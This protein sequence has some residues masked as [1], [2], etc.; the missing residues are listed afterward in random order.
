MLERGEKNQQKYL[1]IC[2][3]Y[4]SKMSE[5]TWFLHIITLK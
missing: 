3:Y 1:I 5:N 4:L 2:Q